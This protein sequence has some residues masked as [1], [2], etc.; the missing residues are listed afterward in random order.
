M[1]IGAD[2]DW[3]AL[4]ARLDA[5]LVPEHL[6]PSPDMLPNLPDPFPIWRKTEAAA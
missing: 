3:P 1:F 5:A 2:I 6:A 4:K